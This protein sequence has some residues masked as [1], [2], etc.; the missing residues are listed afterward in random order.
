MFDGLLREVDIDLGEVVV[1]VKD[2]NARR[3]TGQIDKTAATTDRR[4]IGYAPQIPGAA[5]EH[6]AAQGIAIAR[7]PDE[8][9]EI[10]KEWG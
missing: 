2:G 10:L 7:T 3:L 4:A 8:L 9:I 1:Q 5:W 6:A